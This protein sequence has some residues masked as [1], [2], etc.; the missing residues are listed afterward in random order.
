MAK[1]QSKRRRKRYQPG[2][3]YAG[4]VR[5]TGIL[6]FMNSPQTIRVVFIAMALALA[7][8]GGITIF[9]SN[10]F[11]GG[12]H[13]GGGQGFTDPG[14]SSTDNEPLRSADTE[15]PQRYS[16]PPALTIDTGKRYTATIRTELGDIEVELFDDQAPTTV[17]NFVFLA[18]NGFY[19]GLAF[20]HV[21]QG[22]SAQTGDP[23]GRGDGGPGYELEQEGPGPFQTGTLGMVNGSQFFIA[24]TGSDQFEEF[25]PFARIISGL[26]VA[27]QLAIGTQIQTIEVQE[28]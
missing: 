10:I 8:G 4:D 1:R 27:E 2:S 17:N 22:F 26:E 28:S 11:R 6:S 14:G 7:A 3:A 12:G 25:T 5:P 20:H 21:A 9:G 24:L 19:D 16:S 23:T 13:S 18:R 15:D